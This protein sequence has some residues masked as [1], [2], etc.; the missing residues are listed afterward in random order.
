[1]DF[2]CFHHAVIKVFTGAGTEDHQAGAFTQQRLACLSQI[3]DIKYAQHD[4]TVVFPQRFQLG[5]I[6]AAGGNVPA[7]G[8]IIERQLITNPGACAGN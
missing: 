6:S 7:V 4:V 1:M 3:G 8:G 2:L 5:A